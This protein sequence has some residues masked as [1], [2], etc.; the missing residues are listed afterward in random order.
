MRKTI[1]K[2]PECDKDT[3]MRAISY[4][5]IDTKI[6]GNR[7]LTENGSDV[8]NEKLERSR[9]EVW[10]TWRLKGSYE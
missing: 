10:D 6:A 8:I 2:I 9:H 1:A 4:F 5:P 3:C 7:Q